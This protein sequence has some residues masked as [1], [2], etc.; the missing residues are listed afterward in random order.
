[1]T[2]LA[3]AA[4]DMGIKVTGSDTTELFVTDAILKA[5]HIKW[6]QGFDSKNISTKYDLVIT[7]GSHGG[8]HNLE[9]LRAK[10]LGI[11]VLTQAEAL[12]E[13]SKGKEVIAVCGVGGKTTTSALLA[14]IFS[15][16]GFDP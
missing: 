12:G 9:V 13:F 11:P 4:Q 15:Y 6:V 1:M 5:R 16:C 7:T 8:L 2:S 10:D 14:Y 3:L